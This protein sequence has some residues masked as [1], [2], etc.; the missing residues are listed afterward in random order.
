MENSA[1]QMVDATEVNGKTEN[2]MAEAHTVT[3]K[4]FRDA[5]SGLTVRR[6]NGLTEHL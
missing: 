2:K 5:E 4:E 3:S 1:G 6:L